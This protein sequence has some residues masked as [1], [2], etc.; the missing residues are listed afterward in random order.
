MAGKPDRGATAALL[1]NEMRLGKT[2][3]RSSAS[4]RT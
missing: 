2:A 1:A 4:E 3:T